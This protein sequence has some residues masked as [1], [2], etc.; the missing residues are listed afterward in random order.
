MGDGT[1]PVFDV[2]S[3][4]FAFDPADIQ[5][6]VVAPGDYL[7]L[8]GGHAIHVESTGGVIGADAAIFNR[9]DA[10]ATASSSGHQLRIVDYAIKKGMRRAR[11]LIDVAADITHVLVGDDIDE[12]T[13]ILRSRKL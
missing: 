2:Q 11:M 3:A 12:P 10:S 8:I 13:S 6:Q 9:A 5:E 4:G 7:T 1:D